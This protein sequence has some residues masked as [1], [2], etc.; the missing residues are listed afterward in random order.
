MKI[1]IKG[2]RI[3]DPADTKDVKGDILIDK[4]VIIKVGGNINIKNAT[5]ISANGKIV[6]PGFVDMHTHLREPGKEEAETIE[7]G[8]RAAISGGFTAVSAMPNTMPPCDTQAHVRFLIER[9]KELKS[10]KVIPIGTITKGRK[11]EEITEMQELKDAGCLAVSD[12]GNSVD[13]ADLMRRAMEYASMVGLLM[14]SHCED[15]ALSADGVMNEGYVSTVLGLA[16][17]PREAESTIVERD[18]RL[19]E[20]T[21]ARLHIAHVSVA[22]SVEAIRR[23]K[24]RGLTITAEATPHHFSL[25]D[26]E[27]R[28]FDPNMKV[29]P[30]LRT[31]KDVK[32]IKEALADGT[33]DA[34]ATD[35]APHMESEK[36]KEFDYAP[37][38]MTGLETALSLSVMNLIDEGCLDWTGLVR[39]LSV[40]PSV[41]MGHKGGTL[42][43]GAEADIVVVDP[44]KK[45]VYSRERVRSSS[46]NS[47]FIG[48]EMKGM[49]TDV[50][51]EGRIVLR[52][53]ELV[54][55]AG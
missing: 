50:L 1:V 37:F 13:N 49:V 33:I 48:R 31:A 51:C 46:V 34:I 18:I 2:G 15:K 36:E 24:K 23:A 12:D 38:G 19:A 6:T 7:T 32:A 20:L 55:K 9:A 30:P 16:P 26:E 39:K 22:E 14:I 52:D 8:L 25:T 11:G 17:I 43:E 54:K 3:I 4:G 40:N 42:K 41:I 27:V 10:G 47:P 21:G 29:N 53:G 35:H 5:L 44:D 45:W 28:S